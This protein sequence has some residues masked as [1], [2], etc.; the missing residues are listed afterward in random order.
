MQ[1]RDEF[2]GGQTRESAVEGNRNGEVDLGLVEQIKPV[3]KRREVL[4]LK[5]G[6]EHGGGVLSE[7]YDACHE[8]LGRGLVDKL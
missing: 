4:R 1:E 5:A 2:L 8:A 7:G 3:F 6:T